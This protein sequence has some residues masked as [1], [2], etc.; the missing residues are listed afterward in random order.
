MSVTARCRRESRNLS[1]SITMQA[2]W[3]S[4]HMLIT[5]FTES[6]PVL[7]SLASAMS[8]ILCRMP[9]EAKIYWTVSQRW[10]SRFVTSR[11]MY[12]H[13][14]ASR[15]GDNVFEHRDYL[16]ILTWSTSKR[17]TSSLVQFIY[18]CQKIPRILYGRIA[19]V[20]LT[21]IVL[22]SSKYLF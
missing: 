22:V 4:A 6:D 20:L 21:C 18:K 13:A 14:C 17:D 8:T 9:P 12:V 15:N 19:Y 11:R 1:R 16:L 5:V 3:Y 2:R 10:R 7:S